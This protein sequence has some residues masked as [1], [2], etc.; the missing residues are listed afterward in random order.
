MKVNGT[1]FPIWLILFIGV[2][3]LLAILSLYMV[4]QVVASQPDF[5]ANPVQFSSDV[6]LPDKP[7]Y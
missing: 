6:Y 5:A 2:S 4:A 1:K 7:E 3:F